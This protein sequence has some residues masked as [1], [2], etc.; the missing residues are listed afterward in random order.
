M[1]P[2]LICSGDLCESAAAQDWL[3]VPGA[4]QEQ[5]RS[6]IELG[7]DR[8]KLLPQTIA[9]MARNAATKL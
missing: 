9:L 6:W 8:A 7:W 5:L 2:A 4:A 3:S 1:R